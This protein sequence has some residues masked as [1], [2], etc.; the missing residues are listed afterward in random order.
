MFIIIGFSYNVLLLIVL[1][2][3]LQVSSHMQVFI[4]MIGFALQNVTMGSTY[5][6]EHLSSISD[7]YIKTIIVSSFSLIIDTC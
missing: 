5:H 7:L 6:L 3:H 2:T 4:I 1:S